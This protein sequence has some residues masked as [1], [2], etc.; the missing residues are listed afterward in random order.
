MG[1]MM[2]EI[3]GPDVIRPLGAQPDAGAVIEPE[4]SPA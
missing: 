1:L 4:P 3:I 2:D